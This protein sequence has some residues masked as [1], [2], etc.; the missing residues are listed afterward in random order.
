M[1]GI[2]PDLRTTIME[3]RATREAETPRTVVTVGGVRVGADPF[4]IIAGPCAIES[5]RQI[6][7][8]AEIVAAGGASILRGN[9]YK[10]GSS[11]YS[12]R[13]L[14]DEGL[15]LLRKAGDRVGLPTVTQVLEPHDVAAAA[16]QVDML[17]LHSG[18]M[19]NFELLRE[20]GRTGLPVLL[21]RGPSATLDE[22]LWSAEYLLAE[23][24]DNVV[25]VERGIRTFGSQRDMLDIG[26]VPALKE[27]SHLP[28]IVDPSH[29][30][31]GA[32][33]IPAFA[34]AAQGAGADGLIVE[35]HP[36]PAAARSEGPTQL[37][38]AG[39]TALMFQL[40]VSRM[41]SHIDLIDREIVRLLARRLE[42]ATEIG[43]VKAVHGLPVRVPEREEELLA[44]IREEA[45]R[46][47]IRPE[48]V[49]E[50]FELVLAESRAVQERMR[51]GS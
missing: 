42:M 10:S 4:P 26:A 40:G 45:E 27:L 35:V 8:T 15:A 6:M 18:A 21:R 49:V 11:P 23:G 17:E 12:F 31:G 7:E 14:G 19:Q 51:A 30:S 20:A 5:E 24:D 44:I 41:R 1:P 32:A 50:L 34:L 39:F 9:A 13:G 28:V 43:R 36:D 48:H 47:G 33:K 46:H 3:R 37:D 38:A 2:L 22:L 29:A 25:L 16:S